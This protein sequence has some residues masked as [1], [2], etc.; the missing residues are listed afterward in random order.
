MNTG[1]FVGAVRCRAQ[2]WLRPVFVPLFSF[3]SLYW[4]IYSYG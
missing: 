3:L 4:D 2:K 1:N